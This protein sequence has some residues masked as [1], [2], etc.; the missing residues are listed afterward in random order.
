MTSTPITVG[1]FTW[2]GEHVSGPAA[3]MQ[4]ADFAACVRSIENG[5]NVVFATGAAGASP[6]VEV[7]LL[8]AIQ[9]DYAAWAGMQDLMSRGAR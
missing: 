5:T 2:D 1:R 3:Y 4:S 7:A 8:V 9:T 6:S